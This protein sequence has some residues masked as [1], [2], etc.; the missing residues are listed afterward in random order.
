[1]HFFFRGH[2]FLAILV[3]L[4]ASTTFSRDKFKDY[5]HR[6]I[7][8]NSP[9]KKINAVI[10]TKNKLR[11]NIKI[12]KTYTWYD[13]VSIHETVGGYSGYLLDGKYEE[14]Y[15]PS[16]NLCMSGEFKNGLKTGEWISWSEK[17]LLKERT[18]W[19]NGVLNGKKNIY[20]EDGT[21][22]YIEVY[23]HGKLRTTRKIGTLNKGENKPGKKGGYGFLCR[24][25]KE[26]SSIVMTKQAE[27][28]KSAPEVK[29]KGKPATKKK[30]KPISHNKKERL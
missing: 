19:I 25:R 8:F 2:F 24:K 1:M 23:R 27:I 28:Q 21:L 5:G 18:S 22:M 16:N 30:K 14:F 6:N 7:Y 9:S 20:A 17:G 10:N 13:N 15:F 4:F 29:I 12:S 3:L 26:P 11:S